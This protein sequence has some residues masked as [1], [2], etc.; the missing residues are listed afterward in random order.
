MLDDGFDIENAVIGIILLE[1]AEC[2]LQLRL[3]I[4]IKLDPRLDPPE[5][6]R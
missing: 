6:V 1:I 3:D 4:G 5:Q 2:L